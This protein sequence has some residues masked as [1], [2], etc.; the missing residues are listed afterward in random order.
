MLHPPRS[1]CSS[2][3]TIWSDVFIALH[4]TRRGQNWKTSAASEITWSGTF[5]GTPL[6]VVSRV[7][8]I[9]GNLAH[10]TV[11]SG[12]RIG[13]HDW[14]LPGGHYVDLRVLSKVPLDDARLVRLGQLAPTQDTRPIRVPRWKE[15]L[16]QALEIV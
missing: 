3:P 5:E 10:F 11:H 12:A 2:N 9:F 15:S 14:N 13:A 7:R 16:A 8:L 4:E 6:I 1:Y